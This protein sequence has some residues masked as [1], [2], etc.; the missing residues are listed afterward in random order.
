MAT[1]N[2]LGQPLGDDANDT[3]MAGTAWLF[4]WAGLL[5][6]DDGSPAQLAGHADKTVTIHGT[7][8]AGGSLTIE[9]S[10]DNA[11]WFACT[12][13]QGNAITKTAASME[14]ISE[15]PRYLRPRVTA[16]DGTTNLRCMI[17]ARGWRR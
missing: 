7:F 3:P 16:G 6:T 8:G 4:D 17:V 10:N 9:G 14:A 13:P 5:N 15:N 2:F 1:R 12:D 11:N